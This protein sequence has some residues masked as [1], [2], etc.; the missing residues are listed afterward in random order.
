MGCLLGGLALEDLALDAVAD[1]DRPRLHGLR[2]LARQLDAEQ[3]VGQL[4]AHDLDVIGELEAALEGAAGDAAI[5]E[6]LLLGRLLLLAR[7]EQRIGLLGD[8][9]V[10]LG[11]ARH[12]HDDAIG[13]IARLLDVVGRIAEGGVIDPS[14]R[15]QQTGKAVETDGRPEQRAEIESLHGPYSPLSNMV[16][17]GML[18]TRPDPGMGIRTTPNW[19]W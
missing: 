19:G 7:D 2:H 10:A 12:R 6:L 15:I 18:R 11:E 3:T 14:G 9:E 13:V 16:G 8:R 4:R 17:S 1:L 5:E